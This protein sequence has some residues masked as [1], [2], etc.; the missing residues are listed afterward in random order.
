[1]QRDDGMQQKIALCP[2]YGAEQEQKMEC[3][4]GASMVFRT[5]EEREA[6][7]SRFCRAEF[8][9]CR[10]CG[11]RYQTY[12]KIWEREDAVSRENGIGCKG[13]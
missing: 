7:R 12:V 1:M 8:V 4:G 9:K 10:L 3:E 2:F 5:P 13:G 11:K 6:Y